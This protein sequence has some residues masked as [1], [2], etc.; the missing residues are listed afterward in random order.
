MYHTNDGADDGKKSVVIAHRLLERGSEKIA[1]D[2][3]APCNQQLFCSEGKI[4]N[5]ILRYQKYSLRRMPR[6]SS[7]PRRSRS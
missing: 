7:L 6:P 1:A 4:V 3:L 5:G 2:L